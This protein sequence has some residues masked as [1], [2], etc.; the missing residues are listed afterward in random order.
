M[1]K[2]I[3]L[4]IVYKANLKGLDKATNGLVS[5]Q[6]RVGLVNKA[7]RVGMTAAATVAGAAV[8]GVGFAVTKG[9]GRLQQIEQ[10]TFML[11]GL[12]HEAEG[13]E[14]IMDSALAAVKGTAFGLGD[15]AQIAA[16]AV[17]AGVEPGED[18]TRVLS[19]IADTAAITGRPLSEIQRIMGKVIT[20]DKALRVEL[21][22][23][24]DRGLPIFQMLAEEMGVTEEAVMEMASA[25][26]IS[27]DILIDALDNKIGGAAKKM[28]DSTSGAFANTLAAIQRVGANLIGPIF[29]Q[30]G[31]FFRA[32]IEGLEPIE[33]SAKAVG[34]S[35]GQF[36]NPRL[37]VLV[38]R[39]RNLSPV[40]A[41]I[42]SAF[43]DMADRA[44]S[45]RDFI[46]PLIDGAIALLDEFAVLQPIVEQF[47]DIAGSV[48]VE[49]IETGGSVVGQFATEFLPQLIDTLMQV[50][51]PLLDFA[52]AA[53]TDL[54]PV[55]QTL[56]E[57]L[58]PILTGVLKFLTP[59]LKTVANAVERL[60]TPLVV[61]V[62][63]VIGAIKAFALL[64]TGLLIFRGV[65][66]G[67]IAAS[68]GVAG[69]TYATTAAQKFGLVM[70]NLLSGAYARQ[71]GGLIA[72]T[73]L[74][75]KNAAATV[76][77]A[78]AQRGLNLAF[79]A[80]PI[81]LVVT[82]VAAL[83]AGLIYFFTQTELGQK[84]WE[85]LVQRLMESI[86]EVGEWFSY[87]FTE[88]FPE[89]WAGM[90]EF[91]TTGWDTFVEYFFIALEAIGDFFK[92][93]INGW[94]T[95]FEGFINFVIAGVNG[96]I[97][98]INRISIKVPDKKAFG[99]YAGMT[100]G[101]SIP[102]ISEVSIPRL[103]DGGIVDE[104]TLA[105]IGEAGPEAV[106]PLGKSGMTGNTY[107]ITVN[108]GM[109][110]DGSRVGE[111]IVRAIKRYERQSGPVF[112][113]A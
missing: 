27:A 77:A 31:E 15:A 104:A 108:A 45:A 57:T 97:N 84:I 39:V 79:M 24:A 35:I 67:V 19:T 88:W 36:L 52:D 43:G 66:A 40:I 3:T 83:V 60:G 10:A 103:A 86:A 37:D 4:P 58:V 56:A 99:E 96:L 32:A 76:K 85:N 13:I 63:T 90:V 61:I 5:F 68:Y 72:H 93:I 95:L 106:V 48:L 41:T 20:T 75:I 2:G 111:Q 81:G 28:G 65:Q 110:T 94:I 14:T 11:K 113:S 87:V 71:V 49:A 33:E 42:N 74:M 69:A 100:L 109:G 102:N 6:S 23:L 18:L 25:G 78:L 8:A 26:E 53:L 54:A 91:F 34:D 12:G 80:N 70:T 46:Q 82:V 73:G 47:A 17:A 9:F 44:G 112:A 38:D 107:N 62:A 98:A 7:L 16:Q 50:L 29:D 51:P 89:M 21:L 1:A 30:F 64:K 55:I 105:V 59:I 92:G 22:Q 101:F